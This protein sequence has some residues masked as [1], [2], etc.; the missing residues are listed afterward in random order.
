[1]L[2]RG[3]S[4]ADAAQHVAGVDRM[5]AHVGRGWR[6]WGHVTMHGR[7]GHGVHVVGLQS[8][9]VEHAERLHGLTF[10][11]EATRAASE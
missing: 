4:L 11:A 8:S 2:L 7:H 1:M 6:R 10:T 5:H 9:W 3:A